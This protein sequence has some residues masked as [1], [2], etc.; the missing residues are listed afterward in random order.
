MHG[1]TILLIRADDTTH[2]ALRRRLER[3]GCRVLEAATQAEAVRLTLRRAPDLVVQEETADAGEAGALDAVM[4]AVRILAGPLGRRP[5]VR[6][7]MRRR[8]RRHQAA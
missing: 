3:S 7:A 4:D 2:H 6:S 1:P 8:V 5:T